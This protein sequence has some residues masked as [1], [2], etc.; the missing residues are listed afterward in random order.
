VKPPPL[1]YYKTNSSQY[2][3]VM[4]RTLVSSRA[5][6]VDFVARAAVQLD[7]FSLGNISQTDGNQLRLTAMIARA[8]S[9][10]TA[11]KLFSHQLLTTR[12]QQESRVNQTVQILRLVFD[13]ILLFVCQTIV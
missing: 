12:G 11:T 8:A 9:K 6:N 3:V 4:K 7:C 2:N 1:E 5:R 13:Q 10:L